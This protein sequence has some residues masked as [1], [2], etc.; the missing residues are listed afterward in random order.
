MFGRFFLT[1]IR[2]LVLPVV[3]LTLSFPSYGQCTQPV[4]LSSGASCAQ[5]V[6]SIT[7]S[8]AAAGT[9]EWDFCAGDFLNPSF[10]TAFSAVNGLLNI[11]AGV[12]ALSDSTGDHVFIC[13]RDNGK[14]VRADFD[15]GFGTAPTNF[16][17]L[18]NLNGTISRPNAIQFLR[19]SGIWYSLVTDLSS[20]S[21]VLSV[22]GDGL[23]SLA[24]ASSIIF[25]SGLNL[26]EG[27]DI[28]KTVSDSV[29]ALIA[30]FQDN[31]VLV[32]SFGTSI[33]N[34]PILVDSF[35]VTG[36]DGITDIDV[37]RDC[38]RWYAAVTVYRTPDLI[39]MDLGSDL[40]A[41][42][43]QFFSYNNGQVY[44]YGIR[45]VNDGGRFYSFNSTAVGTLNIHDLGTQ[46]ASP[47]VTFKGSFPVN[48][49]T[50]SGIDLI[51]KGSSWYGFGPVESLN[52]LK[53]LTFRDTC[54]ATPPA[55]TTFGA[56]SV[57]YAASGNYLAS[58]SYTDTSGNT[59]YAS[60]PVQ[61]N[62]LPAVAASVTGSCFGDSYSF[63]DQ[64]TL[65][66][67]ALAGT[68]W[69]YGDGDSAF[70]AAALHVYSDTGLFNVRM[71]SLS[72]AG[73]TAVWDSGIYVAPIPVASFSVSGACSES[74][75]P[76]SDL[77]SVSNGTLVDW[78]WAFGNGDTSSGASPAYSYPAGGNYQV[79]LAVTSDAGCTDRD[80][81]NVSIA[82]RPDG[83]FSSSNTCV[84]QP[85]QFIDLSGSSSSVI[86]GRLWSFGDGDTS[87]A[88]NPTHTY[89]AST[90]NYP[91]QLVVTAAN[92]CTDT[93][94][95]DLRISNPPNV[96]FAV[97]STS[98]CERNDVLFTDLS[99]VVGDTANAWFWDFGDGRTSGLQS[100]FHRYDTAGT[101]IVT[102]IA[103]S[104]TSCPGV[105]YQTNVSVLESP[106]AGFTTGNSCLG[107]PVVFNDTSSFP[108]VQR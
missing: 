34:T 84:N 16:A 97:S 51:K 42:T 107:T 39:L 89:P 86:T 63:T 82:E 21:L 28:V 75:L 59:G 93:V 83:R 56:G 44:P 4:L 92:G 41:V 88:L 30:N 105:P 13:S 33:L 94:F 7:D 20:N 2:Q 78:Q 48:S 24:T 29:F 47:T 3:L 64:S 60:L 104:P 43:P 85:V 101:Y 71:I 10:D 12:R 79:E 46:L 17:D 37:V 22:F 55:D 102:L 32:L 95:Q 49:G 23:D 6:F 38:D 11:T 58:L 98:I 19:E 14:L 36:A 73:C 25:T 53:T 87:S 106:V 18:G 69:V 70:A 9:Y 54:T 40:S 62:P 27:V 57:T 31:R 45:I 67:G 35:T 1:A 81:I 108:S 99:T 52:I 96:S 66:S 65:S 72:A 77:S 26:P 91:L 76:I 80:T 15:N 68:V 61:V 100:P 74:L 8:A 90:G 50:I 5:T 103:Y